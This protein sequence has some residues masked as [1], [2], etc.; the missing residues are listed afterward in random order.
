MGHTLYATYLLLLLHSTFLT[1]FSN[2]I[3][4]LWL[5]IPWA[6]VKWQKTSVQIVYFC[7]CSAYITYY[8][9]LCIIIKLKDRHVIQFT[10]LRLFK[11]GIYLK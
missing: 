10:V 8:Q 1:H 7:Y 5:M 3:A 4:F 2:V 11:N 6:I 9:H